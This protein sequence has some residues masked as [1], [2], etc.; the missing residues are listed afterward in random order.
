MTLALKEVLNI[1]CFKF[2]FSIVLSLWAK[3]DISSCIHVYKPHHT[4]RGVSAL[5]PPKWKVV[6]D[7]LLQGVQ[8]MGVR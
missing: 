8:E 3:P 6:F 7:D 4:G 2:F 1:P 5:M